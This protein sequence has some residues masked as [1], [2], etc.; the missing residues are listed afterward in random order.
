MFLSDDLQGTQAETEA[1]QDTQ[2]LRKELVEAQELARASKQKCF[3]LQGETKIPAAPW[4]PVRQSRCDGTRAQSPEAWQGE[5]G[6]GCSQT[7]LQLVRGLSQLLSA[8][9]IVRSTRALPTEELCASLLVCALCRLNV[10]YLK[11]SGQRIQIS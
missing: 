3:D 8:F 2:H 6:L 9:V 4:G 5:P 10:P 11:C 7:S 1:K